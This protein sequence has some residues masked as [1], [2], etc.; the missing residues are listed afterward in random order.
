MNLQCYNG[1]KMGNK[2]RIDNKIVCDLEIIRKILQE[3]KNPDEKLN[4]VHVAGTNGKGSTVSMLAEILIQ[5][6]Y[7]VGTFISPSLVSLTERIQID[8]SEIGEHE[9]NEEIKKVIKV[10][11]QNN[12]FINEFALL[13][14]VALN[15]FASKKC[16]IVILEVG[17]GGRKDPT[18][19]IQSPILSIITR[20]GL[21]HEEILGKTL[22]E[23]AYEKMGIIKNKSEVVFY[24]ENDYLIQLINE[25]CNKKQSV[26]Y[27]PERSK[28]NIDEISIEGSKFH[29]GK[30]KNIFINLRGEY[31]IQNALVVIESIERIREKGFYIHNRS[32]L[33]GFKK[34]KWDARLELIHNHPITILDGSHNPQG[35]Y[36]T[37]NY[38]NKV[39]GEKRIF[40]ILGMLEDKN[41]ATVVELL[42]DISSDFIIVPINNGRSIDPNKLRYTVSEKAKKLGKKVFIYVCENL[43]QCK[44][45]IKDNVK[46]EDI[47]LIIGSLHLAG[48]IKRGLLEYVQNK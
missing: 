15:I 42:L 48:D 6:K 26:C 5:E 21:D 9:L 20:I 31:Q 45:I 23:I 10:L 19:V 25:Y 24:G 40:L 30:Y 34:V 35:V 22:Q 36:E 13:T 41:Y 38:M 1:E 2:K 43:Y 28:L 44:D 46:Q 39:F 29:Y 12:L 18:N 16:D 47:L 32:I 27:I 8:K 7:K 33:Q 14:I 37:C 11:E 3:F 4:I 17:L